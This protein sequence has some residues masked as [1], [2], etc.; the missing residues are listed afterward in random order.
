[1]LERLSEC[2]DFDFAARETDYAYYCTRAQLAVDNSPL[3]D[4]LF[5]LQQDLADELVA[6][7][8]AGE[9]IG[10]AASPSFGR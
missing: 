8:I 3:Y 5:G 6:G 2:S 10:R 7:K 9:I 4:R 1:M